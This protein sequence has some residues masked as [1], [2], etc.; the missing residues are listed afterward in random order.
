MILLAVEEPKV[1]AMILGIQT[2]TVTALLL[3][4]RTERLRRAGSSR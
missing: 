2:L 1:Q 4:H 3:T